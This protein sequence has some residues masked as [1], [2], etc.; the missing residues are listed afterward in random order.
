MSRPRTIPDADIF[1]A[2]LRLIAE[3]GE[4]SVAFSSVARDTGLAAPSLVQRYGG[5]PSMIHAALHSEWDRL[6]ALVLT[7]QAGLADSSKGPQA[8]LKALTQSPSPA[9]LAASLR[10]AKLRDRATAWRS[11]VEAALVARGIDDETAAML[12]AIWQGQTLWDN[13]GDKAFK[14]KDAIKRLA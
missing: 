12:F 14:L 4:K 7:L 8:L 3:G 9:F 13:L 6:D 10:D 5:L 1:A 2:I 11:Q